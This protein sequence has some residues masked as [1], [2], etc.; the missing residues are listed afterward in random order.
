MTEPFRLRPGEDREL[1]LAGGLVPFRLSL[2]DASGRELGE[3]EFAILDGG[4]GALFRVART[5]ARGVA[6][7]VLLGGRSYRLAL[8]SKVTL[9][10]DWIQV[11]ASI[12]AAA[13]SMVPF[14]CGQV[15]D[16]ELLLV[17]R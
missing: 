9:R 1:S 4:S 2:R 6:D 12:L 8:W 15:I 11:P 5:D 13:E 3:R 10:Q 17:V 16:G 14:D 7:L